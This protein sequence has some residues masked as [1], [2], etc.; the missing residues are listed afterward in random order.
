[1]PP[2]PTSFTLATTQCEAC[3]ATELRWVKLP[4]R[5]RKHRPERRYCT[6]C[7]RLTLHAEGAN[8][9]DVPSLNF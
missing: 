7:H 6:S 4:K 9:A 1:M 8:T 5:A 3:S 2:N